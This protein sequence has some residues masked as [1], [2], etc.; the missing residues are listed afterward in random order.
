MQLHMQKCCEK[1]HIENMTSAEENNMKNIMILE[2]VEP[3]ILNALDDP[4]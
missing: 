2:T 1:Q 4:D 3:A